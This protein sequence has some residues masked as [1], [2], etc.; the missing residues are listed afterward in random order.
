[1]V[2]SVG[3]FLL[4]LSVVSDHLISRRFEQ[5]LGR[6]STTM[7]DHIIV[8]GIGS[9]GSVVAARLHKLGLPVLV[10]ERNPENHYLSELP[11]DV[12]VILADASLPQVKEQAG[13]RRARAVLALTNDDLV[14]LRIAHHAEIMNPK[15]RTVVRL[16]QSSLSTR[17]E[18]S[19]LG[20]DQAFNPS[21]VMSCRALRSE[22]GC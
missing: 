5:M 4:L 16:F 10:I 3:M 17:L 2:S 22:R 11:K 6:P 14:N 19:L 13:M 7:T 9:V 15:A 12:P 21:Q 1:M 8:A 20:I 18:P